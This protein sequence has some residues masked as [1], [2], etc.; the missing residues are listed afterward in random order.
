MEDLQR[1]Q[2]QAKYKLLLYHVYIDGN[3]IELGTESDI[4]DNH[5]LSMSWNLASSVLTLRPLLADYARPFGRLYEYKV[6]GE[7][8]WRIVRDGED[9]RLRHLGIGR[10]SLELRLAGAPGTLTTYQI[11]VSPLRLGY[12]RTFVVHR[13]CH[14][15][16][17]VVPLPQEYI[18]AASGTQRD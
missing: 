1:W 3:P 6:D 4:N 12:P 10:H 18:H 8:E 2:R 7:K 9:I 11:S 16:R 17:L 14:C 15:F 13:C 5:R